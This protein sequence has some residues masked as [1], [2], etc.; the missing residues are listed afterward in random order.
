MPLFENCPLICRMGKSHSELKP[1]NQGSRPMQIINHLAALRD[2]L[3]ALRATGRSIALVPTMGALHRGHLELVKSAQ[4]KADAVIVSIFVNPAQ[5]GVG[6]DLD[7][8][9]RTLQADREKLEAAGVE[10]L[11]APPVAE[12]Y[13]EGFST[14]VH[15]TGLSDDF[16]GAARPGHFDGVA[17]VVAKLF[18]QTQPDFA[19]FGEKDWQQLAIIRRMARDLDFRLVIEGVPIVRDADGLALSSRNQYLS[20]SERAAALALPQALAHAAEEI[21][22]GGDVSAALEYVYQELISAGFSQPDYVALVDAASLERLSTITA[23]PM[24][25]L[26]AAKIGKTR[27]IDNLAIKEGVAAFTT[28]PS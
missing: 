1:L 16:C 22:C 15:M 14:G 13:P 11:W 3:D 10:V 20:E 17:L 25:L 6:E 21:A 5:F 19:F 26:G 12:V 24:R 18:N 7:T 27:L 4:A 28:T 23:R 2:K 9:P 8:Y